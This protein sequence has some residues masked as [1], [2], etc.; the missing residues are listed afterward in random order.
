MTSLALF[1]LVAGLAPLALGMALLKPSAAATHQFLDWASVLL[2]ALAFNLTFFWQELWLVIPKALTP[3]L[4][5]ILY[6]NNHDWTGTSPLVELLQGSGA[7]ATLISGL[8][9]CTVL[10]FAQAA[11]A[12]WRLFL[13]WMATQGLY[14]AL[15]QFAIGALIAGNDV[16]RALAYLG[17][18]ATG[19]MMVLTLAVA[20]M[21][22]AGGWLARNCPGRDREQGDTRRFAFSLLLTLLFSVMLLIPF[23]IPRNVIEVLVIP[24]IVDLFAAGWLIVGMA[25]V[26]P[27]AAAAPLRA[28]SIHG[29]A[30]ALGATLLLFQLVLR[31]GIAF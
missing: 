12:A 16:G 27:Q 8:A 23:R 2:C 1:V 17:V 21:A 28:A 13:F 10:T 5:P 15:S 6:H 24:L 25:L 19:R 29:P 26:R 22:L 31:P 20:G 3:G 30:L 4:H 14:Q 7:I 18:G 11:S 9:F